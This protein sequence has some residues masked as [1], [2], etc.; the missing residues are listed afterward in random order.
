[1]SP[2]LGMSLAR[3]HA[4]LDD[5]ETEPTWPERMVDLN[6]TELALQVEAELM[7]PEEFE[8]IFGDLA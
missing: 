3:F 1:M 6:D 8:R 7:T 4:M 2:R 5:F